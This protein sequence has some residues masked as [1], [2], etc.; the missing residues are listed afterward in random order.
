MG[1][2]GEKAGPYSLW[3]KK[4]TYS[5]ATDVDGNEYEVIDSIS[6]WVPVKEETVE[7]FLNLAL[8]RV[9]VPVSNDLIGAMGKLNMANYDV[10]VSKNEHGKT[11]YSTYTEIGYVEFGSKFKAVMLPGE[12]CQDL[13][14]GGSSVDMGVNGTSFEAPLVCNIFGDGTM[15]LGIMN[16]AI[17]YVVPDNDF[18]M[19][20]PV[21]HYHEL[22]SLGGT[23]ASELM[24]GLE[25]LK[26]DIVYY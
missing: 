19:G 22:I 25:A 13:I 18:T 11:V 7:P 1:V 21:N 20:D 14:V 15:C 17:G 5:K 12:I 3:Y 24:F 16:D 8:K 26:N 23:V 2:V 9:E 10:L 4:Y 6:P